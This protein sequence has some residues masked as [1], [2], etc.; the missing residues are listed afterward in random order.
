M[1]SGQGLQR[2]TPRA[3]ACSAPSAAPRRALRAP[4]VALIVGYG[5]ESGSMSERRLDEIKV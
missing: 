1:G 2:A 5:G 4:A 3:G